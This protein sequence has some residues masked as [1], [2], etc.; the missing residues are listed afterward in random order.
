[1]LAETANKRG[2]LA[3]AAS[4]NL[5]RL[6]VE[7]RSGSEYFNFFALDRTC[8]TENAAPFGSVCPPH[9]RAENCKLTS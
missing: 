4:S 7:S 8:I 2:L 1:M 3:L 5:Y 6:M 9:R